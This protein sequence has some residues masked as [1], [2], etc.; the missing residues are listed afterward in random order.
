M[1]NK[2]LFADKY[3]AKSLLAPSE[4]C[5]LLTTTAISG[6]SRVYNVA[7]FLTDCTRG[8]KCSRTIAPRIIA[9]RTIAPRQFPQDNGPPD[10]CPQ[11]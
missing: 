4:E 5:L 2:L 10:N 6:K 8:K 3:D 9:P 11:G 7:M 1:C